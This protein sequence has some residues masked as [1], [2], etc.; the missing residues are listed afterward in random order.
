MEKR[1]L[2]VGRRQIHYLTFGKPQNRAIV[3]IP[4][5]ATDAFAHRR[6]GE[7][8]ARMGHYVAVV[9]IAGF[10]GTSLTKDLSFAALAADVEKV[11][12]EIGVKKV[13]LLGHSM[14]GPIASWVGW[15]KPEVD[16]IIFV[17][18]AG[19]PPQ[20]SLF[21]WFR[22]FVGNFHRS[23]ASSEKRGM[24]R[25]LRHAL[26]HPIWYWR[27]FRLTAKANITKMPKLLGAKI[28]VLWGGEDRFFPAQSVQKQFGGQVTILG[29]LGHDWI[30]T[31][32][33]KAAGLI[34]AYT[35]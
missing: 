14:G 6:L 21:G 1:V 16:Q 22:A 3:V 29:G 18:S 28:D 20:R 12:E 11:I 24:G 26:R 5:W 17:D 34:N 35:Q 7:E 15:E 10:G 33:T 23:K 2:R 27:T 9:T 25:A 31:D 13:T 32:P 4:G 19:I 8:L 30:L